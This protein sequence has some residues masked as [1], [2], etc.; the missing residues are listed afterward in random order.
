[1]YLLSVPVIQSNAQTWAGSRLD[2]FQLIIPEAKIQTVPRIGVGPPDVRGLKTDGVDVLHGIRAAVTMTMTVA[3]GEN[4]RAPITFH[5]ARG[6]PDI[7][8]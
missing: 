1:M 8:G 6:T 4:V 3:E 2:H 5:H 7:A